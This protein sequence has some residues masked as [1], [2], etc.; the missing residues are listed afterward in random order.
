MHNPQSGVID[1]PGAQC[2]GV[3]SMFLFFLGSTFSLTRLSNPRLGLE[4]NRARMYLFFLLF[5]RVQGTECETH[6]LGARFNFDPQVP[7]AP[8]CECECA[9]ARVNGRSLLFLLLPSYHLYEFSSWLM[10]VCLRCETSSPPSLPCLRR[11]R[12]VKNGAV[13]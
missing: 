1:C 13:G 11:R 12:T 5:T 7:L 3:S 9:C 6:V 10:I 4:W 8:E 2:G